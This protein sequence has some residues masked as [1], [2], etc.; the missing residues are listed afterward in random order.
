MRDR[1]REALIAG[2]AIVSGVILLGWN[3]VT[4]REEDE[5]E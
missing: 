2:T 3:A 1:Q 5:V 4:K